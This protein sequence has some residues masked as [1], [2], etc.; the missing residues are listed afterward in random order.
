MPT[1]GPP[2]LARFLGYLQFQQRWQ[3]AAATTGAQRQL[4]EALQLGQ[5]QVGVALTGEPETAIVEPP[6]LGAEAIVGA[7]PVEGIGRAHQLLVG[8]RDPGPAAIEVGQEP[9]LGIGNGDTPEGGLAANRCQQALLQG[10][11]TQLA[12]QLGQANRR[13]RCR[14]GGQGRR[15]LLGNDSGR[16]QGCCWQKQRRNEP[17][18]LRVSH[19]S[20]LQSQGRSPC[21]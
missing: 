13:W 17:D 19:L 9:P 11:A 8:G 16:Q 12:L 5:G 2:G 3:L 21:H 1:L 20:W 7:E 6:Q 18:R 10:G 14:H 4:R 15:P